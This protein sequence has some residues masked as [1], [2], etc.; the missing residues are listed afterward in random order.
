MLNFASVSETVRNRMDLMMTTFGPKIRTRIG[1]WNVRTLVKASK[2]HQVIQE[3][4]TYKIEILGLSETRWNTFGETTVDGVTF[5]FSGR[6]NENDNRQEGVGFLLSK[7][8]K[9]S[10]LEWRPISERIILARFKTKVRNV[11]IIQCYAPTEVDDYEN[12]EAF[13][14]KLSETMRLI[15]KQDIILVFWI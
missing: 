15:K 8:A 3:M 6:P 4:K 9:N 14:S 7:S 1:T 10:L 11:S 13:Y 12:K 5:L 2:L